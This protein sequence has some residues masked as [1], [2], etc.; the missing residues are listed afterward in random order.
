MTVTKKTLL[1]AVSESRFI[2]PSLVRETYEEIVNQPRMMWDTALAKAEQRYK[3]SG[4]IRNEKIC[5]NCEKIT[6]DGRYRNVHS[7]LPILGS[8]PDRSYLVFLSDRACDGFKE[9]RRTDNRQ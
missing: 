4:Y 8:C 6:P 5:G 7:N 1:R 3:D 2:P 9:K